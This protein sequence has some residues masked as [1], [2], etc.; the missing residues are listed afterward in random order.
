ML[1]AD[2]VARRTQERCWAIITNTQLPHEDR[3]MAFL[4]MTATLATYCDV[5]SEVVDEKLRVVMLA[6]DLPLID[7]LNVLHLLGDAMA[8]GMTLKQDKRPKKGPKK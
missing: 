6:E 4:E 2:D 7:G 1:S 5:E 3:V 8:N